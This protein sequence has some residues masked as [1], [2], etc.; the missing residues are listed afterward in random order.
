MNYSHFLPKS[1]EIA[2]IH[3]FC[4]ELESQDI[5]YCHWKSNTQIAKSE[6]GENDLD[7][8]VDRS[9]IGRFT[10]V[11]YKCGFKEARQIAHKQLP[12]VLDY[13]GFDDMSK[14]MI[15]VHAH[16]QLI[17][18][19]DATKNYR[20]P[21][22]RPFIQ[23]ATRR[24]IFKLPSIEFEFLVFVI[25]MLIKHSTWDALIGF[26]GRLSR[27]EDEEL[28]WL[29]KQM[30]TSKM[31]QILE[32]KVPF[33][34]VDFFYSC[35]E[36]LN[37]E[38]PLWHRF[39]I[40]K[41]LQKRLRAY[42]RRPPVSDLSLKL[43]RRFFGGLRFH[44]FRIRTKRKLASGGAV[45]A[46]VGG[47]GAGKSTAV[48]GLHAWLSKY[49]ATVKVHLGKPRF[50]LVSFLLK[51]LIKLGRLLKVVS[52]PNLLAEKIEGNTASSFPGYAWLIL[53]V[54]TARDRYLV[55]VKALRAATNGNLVVSDRFPLPQIKVMDGAR[56]RN[57]LKLA[58]SP[59]L[60]DFFIKWEEKY[61]QSILPP[62]LLFVLRLDPEIAVKRRS[63]E[64]T[65][66][67]RIKNQAIW[68]QEWSGKTIHVIDA[69]QPAS[70]VMSQIQSLVWKKIP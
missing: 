47:D 55:Y 61:Y 62:E 63:D 24:G 3:R 60:L 19:H 12:G 7:L 11:L 50:S 69:S 57:S 6:L 25:R 54:L 41:R 37:R 10:T 31:N 18:G 68:K 5:A 22:E 1:T 2:L 9:D 14:K 58:K 15:H 42:S 67:V 53:H 32:T 33:L 70:E 17:F 27:S 59:P 46:I 29:A 48:K 26:Q 23:S 38:C 8:L 20:L 34:D 21:I 44:L 52:V 28:G 36:S 30:D 45:I 65:D 40:G 49:F 43:W 56:I 66:L 64:N 39:Q 16:Y 4:Q 13:Y 35:Y 51:G